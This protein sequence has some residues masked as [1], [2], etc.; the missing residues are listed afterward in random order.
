MHK[1][2]THHKRAKPY[3]SIALSLALLFG[4]FSFFYDSPSS[5]MSESVPQQTISR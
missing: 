1:K 5:A 2:T 3:R 4:L